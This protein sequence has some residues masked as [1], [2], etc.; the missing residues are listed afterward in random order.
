MATFLLLVV[1]LAVVVTATT[2]AVVGGGDRAV[3][4]DAPPDA[5]HVPLPHARAVTARDVEELR[6][7]P[8]L[9]GYHMGDVDDVL[10]R[11]AHELADRDARIA[12]LESS[13]GA[14]RGAAGATRPAARDEAETERPGGLLVKREEEPPARTEEEKPDR[15]VADAGES[16]GHDGPREEQGPATPGEAR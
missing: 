6:F 16:G 15:A 14:A 3:L 7:A 5:L 13:L 9:R 8:A 1:A 4:P 10:A 11:L 12:S 2:L